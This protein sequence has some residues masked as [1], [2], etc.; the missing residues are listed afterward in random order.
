VAVTVA[1]TSEMA[2]SVVAKGY[3]VTVWLISSCKIDCTTLKA[4]VQL[5]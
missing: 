2:V 4:M 3:E 1:Y 5:V